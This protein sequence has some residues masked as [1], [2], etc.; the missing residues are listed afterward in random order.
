M[1]NGLPARKKV[2]VSDDVLD[3]LR[4]GIDDEN[5]WQVIEDNYL[6]YQSV[7]SS[8]RFSSEEYINA[9]KYVSVKLMGAKNVDAYRAVFPERF[10]RI[11]KQAE[12][13]NCKNPNNYID[14]F[15]S[16][17]N[18]SLL[19]TRILEQSL[20]PSY[21]LNAPLHQKAI[22]TLA[23]M[24]I[25]PKVKGMARVKA[26]EV[27]LNYTKPPETIRHQLDLTD[28]GIDTVA[29]LKDALAGLAD[30][31]KRGIDKRVITLKQAA[32]G[33]FVEVGDSE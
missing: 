19:V 33:E 23:E 4:K 7:F 21:V 1:G 15:V 6:T 11:V 17:Y 9:V 2:K 31:I 3:M 32:E 13:S 27:L 30:T 8:G 10:E 20:I 24:V 16:S 22:N 12:K 5:M 28:S 18:K 26:C 29:N 14:G 25:D